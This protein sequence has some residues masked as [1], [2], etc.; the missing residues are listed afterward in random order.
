MLKLSPLTN[1]YCIEA[2]KWR[3][4]AR[5]TLRTPY[6]KTDE[7]QK[8]F[9]EDVVCDPRSNH[10]YFA[11]MEGK[12]FIGMGGLCNIE[13]E[14]GR[15]EISL[16][17]NPMLQKRGY[18]KGAVE[19]LLYEAFSNYRLF[20][21]HGE[22]YECNIDIGFWKKIAPQN[23]QIIIPKRKYWNGNFWRSLYF[24]WDRP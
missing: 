5:E 10:R 22:C 20:I 14:N 23:N 3:L 7:M 16:I 15:A 11:V 9:F 12:Q 19:L 4:E 21:V 8:R 1:E 17:V 18:G 24:W 13:W 2:N 6:M